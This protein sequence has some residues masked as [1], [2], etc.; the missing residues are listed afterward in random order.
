MRSTHHGLDRRTFL[1]R[2]AM[3]VLG[4]SLARCGY[5]EVTPL[6]AGLQLPFLTPLGEH[7]MK[8]GA[9]GSLPGWRT[10]RIDP[11]T[12]SMQI[13]GMVQTPQTV[14]LADIEAEGA[15]FIQVLKTMQCVVDSNT[16]QGLVG[17]AMW[18]GVP[19]RIFLDRAG[20]DFDR[21]RRLHMY[22]ADGFTNNLP[23]NKI[24]DGVYT[25]GVPEVLL[26]T[27]MN[28][29]PLEQDH[30]APVRIIVPDGFGYASVKWVERIVVT[31]DESAF[32][33]YQD[34]GFVDDSQSPVFGKITGPTDNLTV[35][36]GAVTIN[37][38]AVSGVAAIDRVEIS[39]DDGPWIPADLATASEALGD[40]P[41]VADA[42]QFADP[43]YSYP[44]RGVWVLWRFVWQAAPGRH[45]IRARAIDA[46][47]NAQ[48]ASDL[49][50]SDGINA[51]ATIRVTAG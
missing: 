36:A 26:V 37:G 3:G 16:A 13:E 34:T 50:I 11:S 39:I 47:G 45:T 18:G 30:G 43:A 12:W 31:D 6:T 22:G 8:N 9:E 49:E 28:G 48:P 46:A 24:Y 4:L 33:T 44:F 23:L 40:S 17:T 2:T 10:P 27:H 41:A 5:Q 35:A 7:Y 19:L 14:T 42:I 25:E 15:E 20:I 51:V 29:Q 1:R 32:G 21:A 38:F